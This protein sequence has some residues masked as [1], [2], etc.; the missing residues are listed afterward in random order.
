MV[1]VK[2][3]NN[4]ITN[5]DLLYITNGKDIIYA[6]VVDGKEICLYAETEDIALILGLCHKYTKLPTIAKCILR[7]LGIK[8]IWSEL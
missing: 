2:A 8:S 3:I 5:S 6:P 4:K 7:I 1:T